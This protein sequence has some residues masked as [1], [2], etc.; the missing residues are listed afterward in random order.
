MGLRHRR[1]GGK[2]VLKTVSFRVRS[3]LSKTAQV[4]FKALFA[5]YKDFLKLSG[6]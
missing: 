4:R 5:V 6:Q 3:I 2:I 1:K